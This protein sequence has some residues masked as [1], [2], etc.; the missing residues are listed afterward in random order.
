MDNLKKLQSEDYKILKYFDSFCELN[1]IKYFLYEGTLLGAIRHN[2]FIPWDDDIDVALK[3][4][5]YEKFEKMFLTSSYSK[6]GYIYHSRKTFKYLASPYSRI[7]SN[8][9]NISEDVP[10]TQKGYNGPWIDI[11][12]LDNIP[13]CEELRIKQFKKVTFY[14]KIIKFFLL[15]QVKNSDRGIKRFLRSII[16]FINERIYKFYFFLP[17]VFKQRD[18]YIQLYNDVE[19]IHS[20]NL[21]Y[22]FYKDYEKYVTQIVSNASLDKLKKVKFE[23]GFFPVPSEYDEI[24]KYQYGDYLIIPDESKRKVHNIKF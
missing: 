12:P 17:Y 9:L 6:D 22:M 1:K 8:S 13:D 23:D 4:E 21:S 7:R 14:N 18:K 3:R 19:T 16:Q 24:L 15:T 20:S 11:L 2:G 5:E 10:N